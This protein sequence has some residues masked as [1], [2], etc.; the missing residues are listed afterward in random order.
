MKHFIQELQLGLHNLKC[1][2]FNKYCIFY[3]QK[4]L[5]LNNLHAVMAVLSALQSAAIFRL[6]KTWLM[7]SRKDKSTYEKIAD[8]FSENNNRQ[9]LR[10]HMDTVKLPCVPYLGELCIPQFIMISHNSLWYP[11]IQSDIMFSLVVMSLNG[12]F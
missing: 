4:L 2:N 8:L 9:K 7:L 5:D 12:T 10:E 6:S 3:F 1:T 11:T